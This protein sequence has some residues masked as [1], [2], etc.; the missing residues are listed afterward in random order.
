MKNIEGNPEVFKELKDFSH[1][2]AV[3]NEVYGFRLQKQ[4][5]K[6]LKANAIRRRDN[7]VTYEDYEEFLKFADYL[8]LSYTDLRR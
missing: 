1:R 6:L 7:K 5:Q 3:V 8:N 4:L 2:Y